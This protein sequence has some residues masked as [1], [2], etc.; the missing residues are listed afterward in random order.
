MIYNQDTSAN[1]NLVRLLMFSAGPCLLQIPFAM[2][3]LVHQ[4]ADG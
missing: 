1:K 4:V 3:L 2:F